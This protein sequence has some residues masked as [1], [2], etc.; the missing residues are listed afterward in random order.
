MYICILFQSTEFYLFY[1]KLDVTVKRFSFE[2][3]ASKLKKQ[4]IM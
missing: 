2:A 1:E 3:L 4:K